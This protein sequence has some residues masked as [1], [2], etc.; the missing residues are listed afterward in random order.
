MKFRQKSQSGMKCAFHEGWCKDRY[1]F[2]LQMNFFLTRL[3]GSFSSTLW[4]GTNCHLFSVPGVCF[5]W[6]VV[7]CC[8]LF[9]FCFG[10]LLFSGSLRL[11]SMFVMVQ[12]QN[13]Q[14][15]FNAIRI[16]PEVPFMSKKLMQ[17]FLK[18][19]RKW[20]TYM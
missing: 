13:Y 15:S 6:P 18:T 4:D 10:M 16:E 5:Y 9:L 1:M 2:L 8:C 11:N 12:I 3:C 19:F 17:L 7:G 14:W 20:V